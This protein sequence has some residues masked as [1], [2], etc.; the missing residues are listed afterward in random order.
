MFEQSCSCPNCQVL[1]IA[2]DKA[3]NYL[4]GSHIC[5]HEGCRRT[6]DSITELNSHLKEHTE[7]RG[8]KCKFRPCVK[9]YIAFKD[10]KNHIS[11]VHDKNYVCKHCGMIVH[12]EYRMVVHSNKHKVKNPKCSCPNCQIEILEVQWQGCPHENCEMKFKTSAELDDH[13]KLHDKIY[14]QRQC[15][16]EFPG[17]G[18][19]YGNK[20]ELMEHVS[21]HVV[22]D[23]LVCETCGYRAYEENSLIAHN[24]THTKFYK[25]SYCTRSFQHLYKTKSH[26]R[27]HARFAFPVGLQ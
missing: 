5:H 26:F 3:K 1:T 12:D 17:C 20:E 15:Q 16:C 25:C 2:G 27:S 24:E 4:F 22:K 13:L 11:K 21:F 14:E 9:T 6:F 19:K 7:K 8:F 23:N 10:L 18:E